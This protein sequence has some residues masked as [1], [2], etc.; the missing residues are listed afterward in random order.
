VWSL[1]IAG[2]FDTGVTLA[3]EGMSCRRPPQG[4]LL[5]K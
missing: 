2:R 5:K 4:V 3:A 1:K